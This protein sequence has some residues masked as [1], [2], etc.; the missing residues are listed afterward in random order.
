MYCSYHEY[1]AVFRGDLDMLVA[2]RQ[3]IR[4]RIED[5]REVREKEALEQLQAE[6]R[7]AAEFIKT[8][9]MQ[10][11]PNDMGHLEVELQDTHA[12]AIIEPIVPGMDL[13]RER[14]KKDKTKK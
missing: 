10:S 9:I 1:I 14:S 8:S 13:P 7:E 11:I 5:A 12:D 4:G 3:E 6:G 2:A